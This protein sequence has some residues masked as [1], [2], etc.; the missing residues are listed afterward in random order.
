M[1]LALSRY[2][3]VLTRRKPMSLSRDDGVMLLRNAERQYD[4]V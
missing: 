4:A 1:E 2:G 3:R